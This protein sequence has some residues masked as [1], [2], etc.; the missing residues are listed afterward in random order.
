MNNK[1]YF[2]HSKT[3]VTGVSDF[4]ATKTYFVKSKPRIKYYGECKNFNADM[5]DKDLSH[6]VKI[7]ANL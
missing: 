5:F 2:K 4:Y 7:K 1:S 3:F 6:C